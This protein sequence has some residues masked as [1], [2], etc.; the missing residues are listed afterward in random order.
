VRDPV[1]GLD[2]SL[3]VTAHRASFFA[4]FPPARN[5]RVFLFLNN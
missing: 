3:E 2:G 4:G 1:F 5:D